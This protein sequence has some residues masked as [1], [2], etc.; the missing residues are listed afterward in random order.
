MVNEALKLKDKKPVELKVI[1]SKFQNTNVLG[2]AMNKMQERLFKLAEKGV[3]L[4]ET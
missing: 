1:I 4:P 3:F 2:D